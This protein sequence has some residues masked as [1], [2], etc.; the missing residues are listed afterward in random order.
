MKQNQHAREEHKKDTGKL[1]EGPDLEIQR[2]YAANTVRRTLQLS[3]PLL[4]LS[5]SLARVSVFFSIRR[6]LPLLPTSFILHVDFRPLQGSC[7]LRSF[8]D[9]ELCGGHC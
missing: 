8:L 3:F 1:R 4:L 6:L 7:S 2:R 5:V 9:R